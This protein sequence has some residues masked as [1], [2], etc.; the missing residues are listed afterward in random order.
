[1]ENIIVIISKL[2]VLVSITLSKTNLEYKD[3]KDRL[4]SA[5]QESDVVTI[6][7]QTIP[8]DSSSKKYVITNN[9]ISENYFVSVYYQ[10]SSI[11]SNCGLKADVIGNTITFTFAPEASTWSRPP[12][13]MS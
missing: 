13:P 9:D 4:T 5:M 1:M 7:N 3:I 10:D 12:K 8:Y 6:E 2:L 11:V